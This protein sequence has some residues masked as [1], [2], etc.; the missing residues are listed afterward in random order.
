MKGSLISGSRTRRAVVVIAS[1]VVVLCGSSSFAAQ[2]LKHPSA[3]IPRTPDGKPDLAA[4]TPRLPDGKPDLSGIWEGTRKYLLNIA[5]DLKP[6]DVPLLPWAAALRKERQENFGKD[7]PDARCLPSGVPK[8]TV[9][10]NPF[11]IVQTPAL[12]LILY[13]AYTTYRQIFTD[14]RML[15][16]DPNPTW[17]G[18][19]VG[20]WD[21]DTLVVETS[22]FNDKTWI[23]DSGYPH[24]DALRVTERYRRRDVGHLEIQVTIDDPKA[25][26]RLCTVTEDARL[27][28]DTE[29]LEFVCLENEKDLPH[30]VGK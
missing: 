17:M 20:R 30:L 8:I 2:W 23:D 29:L 15:P 13:E 14:G 22:G 21:G 19:S 7:R 24:T 5:A 26:S 18:Y 3:G 25:Y 4:A 27:L 16:P 9:V 11:K 10:P 28:P 12:V 1:A 6:E